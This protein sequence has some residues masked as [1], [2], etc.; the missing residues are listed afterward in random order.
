MSKIGHTA[1]ALSCAILVSSLPASPPSVRS[2]EGS[3]NQQ[4]V[5][6]PARTLNEG[7]AAG[8]SLL[9]I[10][11]P[12]APKTV[13]ASDYPAG[14]TINGATISLGSVPSRVWIEAHI[15]AWA[16]ELFR[17]MVLR[18]DATDV[19]GD[20]GGYYGVH[21]D[22]AGLP[23][24]GA[25]DIANAAQPCN[26]GICSTD[27]RPCTSA[28]ECR[29]CIDGSNAGNVCNDS[30]QC[31]GGSCPP[32]TG[33]TC[34][35]TLV[36]RRTMSGRTSNCIN[37]EP[38]VCVGPG[39]NRYCDWGFIDGCDPEYLATGITVMPSVDTATPNFRFSLTVNAD[40]SVGF[41]D[42]APSYGATLVLDVP[43]DA[44]GTYVID[45]HQNDTV[46]W[47]GNP[48]PGNVIPVAAY[49]P[50]VIQVACGSCCTNNTTTHDCTDGLSEAECDALPTS[51]T[52]AH[53]PGMTCADGCC[54]CTSNADC[55][56]DHACTVDSCQGACTC[57]YT[58]VAGWNQATEC[59]D[60]AT[61]AQSL[62]PQTTACRTG[63]CSLGGSSGLPIT[64]DMPNGQACSSIDPC[65]TEGECMS[66]V[67]ET[68]QYAGPYCPK[69]RFISF[70]PES[71]ST[72]HAY[73][74]RLV[75]LHHPNPPYNAA[76]ASDF[77]AFEGEYR[78]ASAPIIYTESSANPAP[79]YGSMAGCAPEYFT[80]PLGLIHVT[81]SAIVPSSEYE[82]QAIAQGLDINVE[83]NYSSPMTIKTSRWSD[84][85]LP[86]N[87]PE[88]TAQPSQADH[89][90][91][92]DKFRSVGHAISK[93]RA[94]LTGSDDLGT[95]DLSFDTSFREIAAS[96]DAFRGKGYPYSGPEVCP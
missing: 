67:C 29:L 51:D 9:I 45:I 5:S 82:V 24:V 23:A 1:F 47:N 79:I 92:V 12:V 61:G 44:K 15:T 65:A 6:G 80:G 63:S 4:R 11:Q 60:P 62:R 72:P 39:G 33:I 58:P 18:V 69:P 54:H 26:T 66:G 34:S 22:C 93:P 68:Q 94:L 7:L 41:V 56:D 40:E 85:I 55:N 35:A 32:Q 91:L 96:V 59:C 38:C 86:Y 14:T 50:A 42:H 77:T 2:A 70:E 43:A 48:A 73:R 87:P 81:G 8:A 89:A 30:A 88:A 17:S 25:G 74:I 78:W 76:V 21:A 57:I 53:R 64:T 90:A 16:P 13:P 49:N 28:A 95:P 46:L 10:L 52:R 3:R 19:D 75:S 36:C 37:G 84:V 31:P 83:A 27:G 71:G 20:G